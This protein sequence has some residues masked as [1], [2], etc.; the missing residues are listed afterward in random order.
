MQRY[1]LCLVWN[2]EYDLDFVHLLEAA[3]SARGLS[4][5][6]ITPDNL[7]AM[8]A[9]LE[10]GELSFRAFL[11]RASEADERFLAAEA[12]AF[13]HEALRL[14]PRECSLWAEDKATMHLELIARGLPTPYTIILPPFAEKP[15]IPSPDLSPLGGSFAIKPA[16]GGGGEGVVLEASSVE[17]VLAARQQYPD[18][19]YLL[20][21]FVS[22]QLLGERP[23]WFRVLF[24]TGSVYP[25]WWDPRSHVYTPVNTE[26]EKTFDLGILP[27]VAKRIAGI[28][29]LSIFST[30][31]ASNR[32]GPY[33]IVDYVNDQIDLRLQSKAVDGVPDA[34]VQNIALNLA[35][36]VAVQR[37]SPRT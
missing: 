1:D 15:H 11:D 32:G 19:K 25:C 35:G 22:P 3:C 2:W 9:A 7:A 33:V 26:E 23:A 31:I 20:Q 36:L 30:E 17:Q 12:W 34:I 18:E 13:S 24:C 6:Q 21:A 4:L 28:C 5:L 14:N 29:K 27:R 10:K 37:H 16:R 8:T